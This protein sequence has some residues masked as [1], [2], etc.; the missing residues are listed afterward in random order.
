[1]AVHLPLS[2]EAQS[3]ARALMLSSNNI[4]S[5]A[6]GRPCASS[7]L[8]MVTGLCHL[9]RQRDDAHGAGQVFSSPAEAIMAYDRKALHLQ[10]PV[11]IRLTGVVPPADVAELMAENGW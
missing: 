3:E 6:P 11:K 5:P 9:S 7:L 4:L 1:M 8:D 2:A 10:A